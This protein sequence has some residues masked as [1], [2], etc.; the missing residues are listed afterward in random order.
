V[1][2]NPADHGSGESYV[3]IRNDECADY[4]DIISYVAEIDEQCDSSRV[5]MEG[6]IEPA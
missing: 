4:F 3:R 5:W 6:Y 2:W 1:G